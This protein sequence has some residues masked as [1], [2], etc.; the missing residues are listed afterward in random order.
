MAG[1]LATPLLEG[2]F[3]WANDF[4]SIVPRTALVDAKPS[5]TKVHRVIGSPHS[6]GI[7]RTEKDYADCDSSGCRT[8]TVLQLYQSP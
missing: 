8:D 3:V 7:L 6:C 5:S 1:D 2:E 4:N